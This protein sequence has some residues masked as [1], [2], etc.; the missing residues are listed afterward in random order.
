M[1]DMHEKLQK[2]QHVR[3][4]PDRNG[5]YPC[6]GDFCHD[7]A[8]KI[9]GGEDMTPF[10]N[11]EEEMAKA[12]QLKKQGKKIAPKPKGPNMASTHV[13]YKSIYLSRLERKQ[14]KASLP[15]SAT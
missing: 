8:S 9:E 15:S 14:R 13:L 1:P 5:N 4:M 12:A 10:T 7:D 2:P 11:S 6:A 3:I